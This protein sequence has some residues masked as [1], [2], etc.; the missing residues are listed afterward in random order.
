MKVCPW[1]CSSRMV[2]AALQDV[3]G[4]TVTK[5]GV[6]IGIVMNGKS[7]EVDETAMKMMTATRAKI[8][9]VGAGVT[10]MTTTT[11]MSLVRIVSLVGALAAASL[12]S[13]A[14]HGVALPE[15]APRKPL[16]RKVGSRRG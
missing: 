7:V 12:R 14:P 9:I 15:R 13:V 16:E 10:K 1:L 3:A 11:V 6:L 5:I 2:R 8:G 4:A